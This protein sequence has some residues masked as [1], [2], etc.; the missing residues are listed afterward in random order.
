MTATLT[1][2]EDGRLTL[3]DPIKRV[4]GIKPGVPLRAEVSEGRLEIGLESAPPL[5]T[6]FRKDGLPDI[7]D[8]W[9]SGSPTK[10]VE[11]IKLDREDRATKLVRP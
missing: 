11:A 2:D 3:P 4:F 5:V 6:A 9:I 8:E 10:I 7:P 1:L